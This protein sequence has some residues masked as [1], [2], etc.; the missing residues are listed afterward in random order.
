[1]APY[2]LML[3]QNEAI[4]LRMISTRLTSVSS[5][6]STEPEPTHCHDALTYLILGCVWRAVML[7][8]EGQP[9][10]VAPSRSINSLEIMDSVK[11]AIPA[12]QNLC[13]GSQMLAHHAILCFNSVFYI[14]CACFEWADVFVVQYCPN[15]PPTYS[16]ISEKYKH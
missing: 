8:S 1:M 2:G 6:K 13:G 3:R 14:R 9:V 12:Y 7:G 10:L 4:R 16:L 15:Q 11:L 5:S